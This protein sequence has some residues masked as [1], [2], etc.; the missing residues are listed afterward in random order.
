M[1]SAARA[2]VV[3]ALALTLAGCALELTGEG[4]G[5]GEAEPDRVSTGF[6]VDASGL[7][8]TAFHGVEACDAIVLR[9]ADRETVFAQVAA[10]DPVQDLALLKT[11]ARDGAI[12]SLAPVQPREGAR[13]WLAG[14]PG[15]AERAQATPVLA[16]YDPSQPDLGAMGLEGVVR[17]GHSGA[18][19]LDEAGR[20][21][22]LAVQAVD[23]EEMRALGREPVEFGLAADR[24]A[25]AAFLSAQGVAAPTPAVLA[26][27]KAASS[28]EA[29]DGARGYLARVEC[30]LPE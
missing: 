12:A 26:T 17:P 4:E 27:E 18:P 11:T 30:Y 5:V 13:L 29:L 7:W 1:R 2:G 10:V 6:A 25:L 14:Y 21:V 15:A 3:A 28:E 19:V 9:D 16:R 22:G 23:V 8:L 20:V 24:D